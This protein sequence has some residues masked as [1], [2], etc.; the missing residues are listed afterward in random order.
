MAIYRVREGHR[1]GPGKAYGPGD[2]VQL[3]PHEAAPLADVLEL[4]DDGE[5]AAVVAEDD[6]GEPP[7]AGR[8]RR[9]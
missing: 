4:V 8:G 6:H 7:T 2:L 5:G 9:K 3:E 1:Y